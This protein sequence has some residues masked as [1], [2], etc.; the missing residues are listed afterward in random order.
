MLQTKWCSNLHM[1]D[2]IKTA[3]RVFCDQIYRFNKIKIVAVKDVCSNVGLFTNHR[4]PVSVNYSKIMFGTN[5]YLRSYRVQNHYVQNDK[6]M[7]TSD[8]LR[9]IAG[10]TVSGVE[11]VIP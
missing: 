6:Y 4:W 8:K 3:L 2:P 1:R 7:Y 11:E 9:E 5:Y 10:K